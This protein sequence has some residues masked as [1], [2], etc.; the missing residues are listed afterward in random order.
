M[1][2]EDPQGGR[3]WGIVLAAGEGNRVSHFIR[4]HYGLRSP[5]QYVAFTGK[6][7][8]LQH[9]LHRAERRIPRERI[10]TVVSPDH[11][12]EVEAQLSDRPRQTVI[13]QPCNRETAPGVLLP[14]IHI[15]KRDPEARVAIFPSDHFIL[16]EDRFMGYVESADRAVQADPERPVLLGI[17]VEDPEVEYGRIEPAESIPQSSGSEVRRV[18]RFL[19]KPDFSSACAF[20]RKG[21]LWNTF[22]TVAKAKTLIE[23]T[24]GSLFKIWKRFER[25]RAALGADR[26]FSVIEKEY[27]RMEGATLSRGVFEKSPAKMAVIEVR[28]VLWSDWGSGDRIEATLKRIG[29]RSPQTLGE[30][31]RSEEKQEAAI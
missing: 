11:I 6:R 25:M 27:A 26:E 2:L 17:R 4:S 24:K 13:F 31:L 22:V 15:L 21:Y 19:E 8:M 7:S 3:L 9:T 18:E 12:R 16:E 30:N 1:R 10:L 29:K 5:K 28:G 14:L 20:F 23:M